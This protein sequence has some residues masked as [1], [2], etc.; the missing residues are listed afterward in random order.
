MLS[1]KK[2][3]DWF[4]FLEMIFFILSRRKLQNIEKKSGMNYK[5]AAELL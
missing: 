5:I 4:I 1:F 2:D 3:V